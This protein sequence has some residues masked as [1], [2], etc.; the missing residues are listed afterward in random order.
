[1]IRR[2]LVL[3]DLFG[4]RERCVPAS[5]SGAELIVQTPHTGTSI[6]RAIVCSSA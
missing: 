1:M 5:A 4:C 3:L 6:A 2:E